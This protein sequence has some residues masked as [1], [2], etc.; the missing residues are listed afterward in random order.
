MRALVITA[1]HD[2]L[3]GLHPFLNALE[4][5]HHKDL[6]VYILHTEELSKD[7]VNFVKDRFSYTIIPVSVEEWG[8]QTLGINANCIWAKYH[9]ITTLKGYSAI[10]HIDADCLLLGSLD[11][12]FDLVD[13]TNTI[14]CPYNSR[15]AYKFEDYD[16]IDIETYCIHQVLYNYPLFFNPNKHMDIMHYMWDNRDLLNPSY[17]PILFNKS[18]FDLDKHKDVKPLD[19]DSWCCDTILHYSAMTLDF[20]QELKII[21][22][23][24]NRVIIWHSRFWI[25]SI[26]E[27][28]LKGCQGDFYKF[29]KQNIDIG[30]KAVDYYS[31][32]CTVTKKEVF[33][34]DPRCEYFFTR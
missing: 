7:Y 3:A 15:A 27:E 33:T 17:D 19:S 13:N 29:A 9:L 22:P 26:N 12:A 11:Y 24:G 1:S 34:N 2:Y 14:C 8:D 6:D 25:N 4:Y 20:N 32:N 28:T 31:N 30:I 18:L 16:K 5:Y 10:C 21:N 23:E